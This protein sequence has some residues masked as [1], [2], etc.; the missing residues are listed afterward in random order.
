[1][2]YADVG[3]GSATA[4]ICAIIKYM[5]YH[6]QNFLGISS[7]NFIREYIAETFQEGQGRLH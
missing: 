5:S 3:G 4:R 7:L 1:M 2:P 6:I